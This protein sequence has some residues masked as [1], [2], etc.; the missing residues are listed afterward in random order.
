MNLQEFKDKLAIDACGITAQQAWDKGICIEC[1]QTAAPKCH[2]A[3]G[4]GEYRI[5]AMC[6]ECFDKLF[7]EDEQ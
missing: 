5:S 7:A 3:A 4:H 2:T 6:E 1:K